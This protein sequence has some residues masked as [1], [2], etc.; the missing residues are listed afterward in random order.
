MK[1]YRYKLILKV[2]LLMEGKFAGL[3]KGLIAAFE[4]AIVGILAGVDVSML[5]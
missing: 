2:L 1:F 3:F 5:S 4:G